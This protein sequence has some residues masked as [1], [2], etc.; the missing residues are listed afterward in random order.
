VN[1][2][3]GSDGP[4][5][6]RPET[7]QRW[8]A[9]GRTNATDLLALHRAG[10]GSEF[11]DAALQNFP[12]DP[13]ALLASIIGE[14]P[15]DLVRE[16]LERLRAADPQNPLAHY[17]SAWN[18]LR[19]GDR[20][21]ALNHLVRA[22]QHTL[23]NDYTLEIAR[24]TEELRRMDGDSEAAA[25]AN[26]AWST[27][28]P[29]LS[30]LKRLSTDLAALQQEFIAAG[31][32]AGAESL[33]RSGVRLANH[34]KDGSGSMTLIG[35]LV[36]IAIGSALTRNLPP[37]T[38]YPFLEGTPADFQAN[39]KARREDLRTLSGPEPDSWIRNASEQDVLNYF[40]AVRT[41]GESTALRWLR[42][43][44]KAA[45]PTPP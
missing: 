15:A 31:D 23:Y 40:N 17:L 39:L 1:D 42:E 10:A 5:P 13:R 38:S 11:L 36:G 43:E 18:A 14:R 24:S 12:N 33:A 2:L 26:S 6:V 3:I 45:A 27:Q 37:S 4:K 19:T 41:Y 16:R 44:E 29:H 21:Q 25:L 32:L 7:V 20:E 35:E 22:D 9:S 34:L 30:H 8:L 28:L